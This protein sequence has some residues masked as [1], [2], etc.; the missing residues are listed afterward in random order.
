MG[1]TVLN[2]ALAKINGRIDNWVYRLR[3]GQMMIT[4]RP[5][6]SAVVPSFF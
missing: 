1:N 3:A 5:D 4:K 6:F 2:S